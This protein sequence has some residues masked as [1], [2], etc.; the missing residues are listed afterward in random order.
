MG[1]TDQA[2]YGSGI[3][4]GEFAIFGTVSDY[5]REQKVYSSQ[6]Y[7][8]PWPDVSGSA[9][10]GFFIGDVRIQSGST[11][12]SNLILHNAGIQATGSC[13]INL[14]SKTD[15]VNL[16]FVSADINGYGLT[17]CDDGVYG[18]GHK[19]SNSSLKVSDGDDYT[20]VNMV[21]FLKIF[22]GGQ[23]PRFRKAAMSSDGKYQMVDQRYGQWHN[24]SSDYGTTWTNM[25]SSILGPPNGT[26]SPGYNYSARTNDEGELAISS[27]G[28][29]QLVAAEQDNVLLMS[30]DYGATWSTSSFAQ[31]DWN[32]AAISSDG[33]Y[34]AATV[35]DGKVYIT[36]DYSNSWTLTADNGTGPHKVAMSSTGK[37]M[38]RTINGDGVFVSS[39]YGS[40]WSGSIRFGLPDTSNEWMNVAMSSNGRYQTIV[41]EEEYIHCS[42]DYGQTWTPAIQGN[43]YVDKYWYSVDMTADGRTQF[44]MDYSTPNDDYCLYKSIDYGGT[45]NAVSASYLLDDSSPCVKCTAD[46]STLLIA[47]LGTWSYGLRLHAQL[48]TNS[49]IR[50]SG[51][52]SVGGIVPST[53]I[54]RIDASNDIVAFSTSDIRFKENVTP[55]SDALFKVRQIRGVEFDWI[56][57]EEFHGFEGHDVGVIAQEVEKVLPEVV[58]TRD[59][60]Y[61][62]LKY[63]RFTPL[64][65]EAIKEQQKQI[66]DLKVQLNAIVCGS[67]E[68]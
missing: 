45:W 58:T 52:L 59:S 23:S 14:G 25:S 24:F 20:K 50:I 19:I 10:A 1:V 27:D 21:N 61:K 16:S 54:G 48:D 22:H 67:L 46:G 53:T 8:Q 5:P 43:L 32:G 63:E 49:N 18:G 36:T 57:N 9:F 40:N 42:S 35:G 15:D 4:A 34:Q 66:D 62:A 6:Y 13:D 47:D 11:H 3:G 44:A 38:T 55:I 30:S 64:L 7:N 41:G 2:T 12:T 37:Y 51:S 39:D 26:A 33:K 17:G 56:P 60:G 65:I 31:L 28:K 68:P 29:Y